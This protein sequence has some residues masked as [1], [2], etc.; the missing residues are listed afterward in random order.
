ML[1][2]LGGVSPADA[3]AVSHSDGGGHGG[4]AAIVPLYKVECLNQDF[5]AEQ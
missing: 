2:L 4:T 5:S 3:G 1:S